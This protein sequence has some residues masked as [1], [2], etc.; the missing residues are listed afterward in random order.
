MAV[1]WFIHSEAMYGFPVY[2][3]P[4][5]TSFAVWEARPRLSFFVD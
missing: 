2:Q 1:L 4:F 3:L 5:P